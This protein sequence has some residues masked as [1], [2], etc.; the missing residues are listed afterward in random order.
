MN[1]VGF[2]SIKNPNNKTRL[3]IKIKR[4]RYSSNKLPLFHNKTHSNDQARHLRRYLYRK[5]TDYKRGITNH[6]KYEPPSSN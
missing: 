6:T 3:L 5:S 1:N 2:L 4:K